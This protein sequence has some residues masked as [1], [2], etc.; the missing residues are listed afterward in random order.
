M[1]KLKQEIIKLKKESKKLQTELKW[2]KI[3]LEQAKDGAI[4]LVEENSQRTIEQYKKRE[5]F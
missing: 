4:N 5:K 2:V 3:E 1:H